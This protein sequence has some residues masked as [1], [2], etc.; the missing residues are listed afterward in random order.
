MSYFKGFF[1]QVI[2]GDVYADEAV[3]I[4]GRYGKAALTSNNR[5]QRVSAFGC[6]QSSSFGRC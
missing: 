5:H 3:R 6:L 4:M 1:F 2:F